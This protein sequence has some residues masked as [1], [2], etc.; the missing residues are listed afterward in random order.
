MRGFEGNF[1]G[2]ASGFQIGLR[3]EQDEYG[4]HSPPGL[5]VHAILDVEPLQLNLL[6][7]YLPTQTP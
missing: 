4:D 3:I 1:S 5:F 7:Q 2:H 6:R